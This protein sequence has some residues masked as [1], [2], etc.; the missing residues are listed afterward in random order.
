MEDKNELIKDKSYSNLESVV[1]SLP[2]NDVKIIL[3]NFNAKVRTITT[4]NQM[5]NVLIEKRVAY[6]ILNIRLYRVE[7]VT[8]PTIS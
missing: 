3:G 4:F 2:S 8:A 7:I 6:S 1:E 5:D